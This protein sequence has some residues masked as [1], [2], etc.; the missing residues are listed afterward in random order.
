MTFAYPE[1]DVG[2]NT[3]TIYIDPDDANTYNGG[4]ITATDWEDAD[5]TTKGR[6]LVSA[7][8]W[9]DEARW[10]GDQTD[11]DQEHAWPRTDIEGVASDTLPE[12]LGWACAAL[13]A[14]MASDPAL[15]TTLSAPIAR[16]LRAGSASISYFRPNEVF[17]ATF[18]PPTIMSLVQQWMEG[19]GSAISSVITNGTDEESSLDDDLGF[20]HGV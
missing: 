20:S 8:R 3:Y 6:L 19:S 1:V 13:A 7:T 11:E 18:F 5:A 12:R 9:L 14:L 2:S 16:D 4:S 10:Q 15:R 17:V